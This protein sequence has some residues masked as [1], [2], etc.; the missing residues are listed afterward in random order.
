MAR[1]NPFQRRLGRAVAANRHRPP[2]FFGLSYGRG[3]SRTAS[4]TL[5][6]VVF[7][8]IPMAK[9][10]TTAAVNPGLL[11]NCRSVSN[12]LRHRVEQI[13]GY[14]SRSVF[15]GSIRAIR[16]VGMLAA[17]SETEANTSTAEAIAGVS[18][19]PTP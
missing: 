12:V 10:I 13:F 6:T 9:V 3:R 11:R 4:I 8:A 5:K 2:Y 1:V 7:A 14:S 16:R 15:A 19:M 17:I 18:Y